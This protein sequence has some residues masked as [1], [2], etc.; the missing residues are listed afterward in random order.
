MFKVKGFSEKTG[1]RHDLGGNDIRKRCT[2]ALLD[3][4]GIVLRNLQLRLRSKFG[5]TFW[6]STKVAL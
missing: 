3:Y 6:S 4:V 1:A 5:L 2:A